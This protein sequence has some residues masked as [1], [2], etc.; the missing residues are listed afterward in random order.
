[1]MRRR[2]RDSELSFAL[3]FAVIESYARP[4]AKSSFLQGKNERVRTGEL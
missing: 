4:R 2:E 1:M 3:T